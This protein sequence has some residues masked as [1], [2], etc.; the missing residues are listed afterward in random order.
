VPFVLL[1]KAIELIVAP[2]QIVWDNGVAIATGLGFTSTVAVC[3]MAVQPPTVVM[4]KVTVIGAAVVFVNA[5]VMLPD[6]LAAMP[7]TPAVLFLVQL[8][9]VPPTLL[10]NT[11][12]AMVDP[13]Q[14][15]CVNGVAEVTGAGFTNTVAVIGPP[16]QLL[17]VMVNVTVTG[18]AVVLVN[19]PVILPVPLAGIPVTEAV[20]F[21][22]QV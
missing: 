13:E 21:L 9:V 4:V 18:D 22:V 16:V 11:T 7:V 3:G 20:L 5:P 10:L 8:K 15:V 6:P 2:E 12:G 17:G 1:L 19:A 14:I